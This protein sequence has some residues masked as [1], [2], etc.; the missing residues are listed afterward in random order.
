MPVLG[1]CGWA[2]LAW[3]PDGLAP[4]WE[5]GGGLWFAGSWEGRGPSGTQSGARTFNQISFLKHAPQ[6]TRDVRAP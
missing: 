4:E 5:L 2:S 1:P 6:N 3:A